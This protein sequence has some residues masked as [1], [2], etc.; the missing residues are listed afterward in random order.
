MSYAELNA[1]ANQLSLK[2]RREY[3]VQPDDF[4]AI[5]AERSLEMVIGLYAIIKSGAAYVPIDPL[6]PEERISIYWKIASLKRF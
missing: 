2:L 1:R 3:H 5:I 4:V 6:Y